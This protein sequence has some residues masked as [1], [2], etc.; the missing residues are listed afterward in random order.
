MYIAVAGGFSAPT[1]AGSCATIQREGSGG[2]QED[3]QPL[4]T[5]DQLA[6]ASAQVSVTPVVGQHVKSEWRPEWSQRMVLKM[7]PSGQ[8][9]TFSDSAKQ[10]F[11]AQAYQVSDKADR[12]GV[13]LQGPAVAWS[14]AGIVSEPLA[15]GA[16]QIP[17]DGQP[18]VMLNDRQT[19]GGYPK[20]GVLTWDAKNHLAQAVP[21]TQIRFALSDV[22]SS[23]QRLI[24]VYG[25]FG[26]A[27]QRAQNLRS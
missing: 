13:R 3:G 27:C 26:V 20:I 18:I 2:L 1:L 17:T 23:R 25:F 11:F 8:Y 7:L 21:G 9:D 10:C 5:G 6:I 14:H 12:M 24:S 16:I 15:I 4:A 22:A 19:L